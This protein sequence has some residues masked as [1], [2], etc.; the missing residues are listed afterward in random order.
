[1]GGEAI[2]A[3]PIA[4]GLFNAVPEAPAL[5]TPA[6]TGAGEPPRYPLPVTAPVGA[7]VV[8]YDADNTLRHYAVLADGLQPISPVVAAI[9][10]NTNS[11][12]LDQPPR[13]GADDVARLP[14][15]HAIDN[16]AYP[17]RAVTLVDAAT[18]PLTCA[19]WKHP[20]DA[21]ASTVD[22]RSGVTLPI[23]DDLRAVALVGA[24]SGSTAD[25]VVLAPGRGYFV[26]SGGAYFWLSDTGVR[27]GIDE[28]DDRKAVAALG[29]TAPALPMPW[30][31]L[32]QFAAGPTLGRA[33]AMLA[34]DA[35]AADPRPAVVT[36]NP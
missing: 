15:S 36:E 23:S 19:E 30:S 9:L 10:R 25:R 33:D 4:P 7:V 26:E 27:Y 28:G 16:D 12:G 8:S 17:A 20:A 2:E 21:T 29:L 18:A 3:R 11:F 14:V 24:G 34:H 13:I 22:V 6:I 5:A 35:L 32:S 31:V 1:L